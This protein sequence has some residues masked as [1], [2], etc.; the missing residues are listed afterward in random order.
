MKKIT[1]AKMSRLSAF[2]ANSFVLFSVFFTVSIAMSVIITTLHGYE[3]TIGHRGIIS[4]ALF[5]ATPIVTMVLFA[6]I[7]PLQWLESDDTSL[8]VAIPIHFAVSCGLLLGAIFVWGLI[9]PLPNLVYWNVTL[10]Y[11]QGYVTIVVGAVV[12]DILKTSNANK[13]LR[14]LHQMEELKHDNN[15]KPN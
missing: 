13:N 3:F 4:T 9:D 11:I 12:I 10:T 2:D 15:R 6:K 5:C 7:P 14:K 8:W 1:H